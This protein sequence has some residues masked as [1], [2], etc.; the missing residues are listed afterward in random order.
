MV[1]LGDEFDERWAYGEDPYPFYARARREQ[2]IFFSTRFNMWFVTRHADVDAILRDPVTFSSEDR[3]MKPRTWPPRV[4]EVIGR[5]RHSKHLGNTDPPAHARLRH[6]LSRRFTPSRVANDSDM[7]YATATD[8]LNKL[9]QPPADIMAD[10]FYQLP[11]IVILR[12]IGVPLADQ[13][14]CMEM[15]RL[16]FLLDFASETLSEAEMVESAH[17]SV[18]FTKYCEDLVF[19]RMVSP[20]PDLVSE[21]LTE[22]VLEYAPLTRREVSDLLPIL[23][24]AGHETTA[25]LMGNVLWEL[26]NSS[27]LGE[28]RENPEKMSDLVEEGLRFD[29]PALGF[30]RRAT[31]RVQI[32]DVVLAEGAIIFLLFGSANRDEHKW[33]APET[34]RLPRPQAASHLAFGSGIHYCPGAS[35]ARLES[36]IGLSELITRYPSLC[37][38]EPEALPQ[39]K[40]SLVLRGFAALPVSW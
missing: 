14:Y 40:P 20:E 24:F 29:T 7:V 35:L 28:F 16:K 37:L 30:I 18:D 3:S 10:Y 32:A 27:R 33:D 5:K 9:S 26:L 38:A 4:A 17:A 21:L 15:C 12:M 8:L 31:R 13:E 34:F 6:L 22:R 11:L 19:K 1:E 36:R 25:K 23:I 39:R 2:P